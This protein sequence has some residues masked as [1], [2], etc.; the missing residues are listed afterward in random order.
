MKADTPVLFWRPYFVAN[1]WNEIQTMRKI[2]LPLQLIACIFVLEVVF[3]HFKKLEFKTLFHVNINF[4]IFG[5]SSWAH[6]GI[7]IDSR[8]SEN[9]I[10]SPSYQFALSGM[11]FLSLYFIQLILSMYLYE[12]YIKNSILDFMDVCS[13]ANVSMF[14]L[15]TPLH[16]YYLH[17]R[18]YYLS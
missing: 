6:I 8:N 15:D 7:Q 17:G 1:E 4:Q 12:R 3:R 2:S 5:V 16:G 18:Y 13:I 10:I 14:I 11:V 9:S